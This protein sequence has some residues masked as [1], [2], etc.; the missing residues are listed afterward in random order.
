MFNP[1][2]G[3]QDWTAASRVRAWRI[4][5]DAFVACFWADR[6]MASMILVDMTAR[7]RRLADAAAHW[8]HLE[9]H[10]RVAYALLIVSEGSEGRG[11]GTDEGVKITHSKLGDMTGLTRQSVGA[12]LRALRDAGLVSLRARH[13]VVHSMDG[14][15]RLIDDPR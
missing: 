10:G 9:A 7:L 11:F 6:Q 3:T 12:A 1:E 8:V 15:K 4:P 2:V 5:R 13:V 14:L